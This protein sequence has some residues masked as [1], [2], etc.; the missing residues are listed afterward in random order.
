[1]GADR[2]G[3][4]TGGD[5]AGLLAGVGVVAGMAMTP[6]R[7]RVD[8][9]DA[10]RALGRLAGQQA[11]LRRVAT[12][13]ARGVAAAEVFAAVAEEAGRLLNAEFATVAR[14][15]PD[16]TIT[17]MATWSERDSMPAGVRFSLEGQNLAVPV[18]RTGRSAR[19]ESYQAA[20]GPISAF[21]DERGIRSGVGSPIVVDGRLWGLVS[22][23]SSGPD[24]PP[25]DTEQRL[26]E[27][28]ELVATAISNAQARA[29]L[30]ASRRRIVAAGDRARRR[31]ERDL[32]DGIQQRLVSLALE[33]RAAEAAVPPGSDGLREQLG[34]IREGLGGALDELREVSH[35]IHPAILSQGGLASA[36][37][38]LAR[39]SALA[40]ELDLRVEAALPEPVE[41]AAYYVVAEALANAA[42]HARASTVRLWVE[43]A[44][45]AIQLSV[46]DDGVGGADLSR[47]TGLIG[48][49]DRVEALGGTL[50]IHSP[51]GEGTSVL[52]RLPL[53]SA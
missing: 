13:V 32:H 37:R 24:P 17:I 33:L 11:A 47:G 30:D 35:G 40:V 2:R 15:E 3:Q 31:I 38:A 45:G 1:M 18:L 4:L 29:E 50:T 14:Y 46:R 53:D 52:V 8:G 36:L 6:G 9:V 5:L 27:F 19:I 43:A 26:G 25:P 34:R 16:G 20:D 22:I 23:L 49:R 44:D 28:T 39:R 41:V 12:L 7:G 51:R 42:K 21:L 10:E 48:L